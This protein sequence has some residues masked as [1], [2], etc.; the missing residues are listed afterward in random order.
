MKFMDIVTNGVLQAWAK[1]PR[2]EKRSGKGV[3]PQ[4]ARQLLAYKQ[5]R[6]GRFVLAG[7]GRLQVIV[8]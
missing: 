2:S 4:R 3:T 7:K 6:V 1:M 5:E 8:N